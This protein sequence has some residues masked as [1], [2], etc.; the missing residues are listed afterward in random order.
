MKVD[1]FLS[2]LRRLLV[3]AHEKFH[4][5][6]IR[7]FYNGGAIIDQKVARRNKRKKEK[8]KEEDVFFGKNTP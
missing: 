6:F 5:D 7:G 1:N 8:I 3:R 4:K 2:A